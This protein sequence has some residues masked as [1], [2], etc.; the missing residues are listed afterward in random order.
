LEGPY[1]CCKFSN[2]GLSF[3]Y[4]PWKVVYVKI[5]VFWSCYYIFL[6]CILQLLV[7][8]FLAAFIGLSLLE[9][10]FGYCC[11]CCVVQFQEVLATTRGYRCIWLLPKTSPRLLPSKG[12]RLLCLK[13]LNHASIWPPKFLLMDSIFFKIFKYICSHIYL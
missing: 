8:T 10:L 2:F 13:T 12:K 11:W 6:R 4:M 7:L 5:V 3:A 9:K 1:C